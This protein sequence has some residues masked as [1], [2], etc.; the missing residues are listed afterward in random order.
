MSDPETILGT[1]DLGGHTI[2]TA[3]IDGTEFVSMQD[4]CVYLQGMLVKIVDLTTRQQEQM[5]HINLSLDV[6]YDT[7]SE[8]HPE[9]RQALLR[10]MQQRARPV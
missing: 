7:L 9:L 6:L 10:M 3:H 1:T 4:F 2:R 5:T 8:Q